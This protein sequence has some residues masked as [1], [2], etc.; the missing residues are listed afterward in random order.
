MKKRRFFNKRI[1][2]V[3][4]SAAM[5]VSLLGGCQKSGTKSSNAKTDDTKSASTEDAFNFKSVKDVTFPLKQK[6]ELTG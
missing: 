3:I 4:A 6:L 5:V 2:S 1:I